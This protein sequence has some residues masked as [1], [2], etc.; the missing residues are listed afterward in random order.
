MPRLQKTG[1]FL[2]LA[3]LMFLSLGSYHYRDTI[4]RGLDHLKL[5]PQ[6]EPFTE[7]YIYDFGTLREAFPTTVEKGT[8]ISFSFV[9]HN[10]EGRAMTYPYTIDVLDDSQSTSTISRGS[11]V[12]LNNASTTIS[13]HYTFKRSHTQAEMFITL[14]DLNQSLHFFVPNK[15]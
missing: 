3:A 2:L 14:P 9:I 10:L 5:L 8:T 13:T 11:V 7:L 1:V 12:L 4:Y 6:P 15:E